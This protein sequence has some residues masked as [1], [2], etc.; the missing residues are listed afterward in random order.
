VKS[1]GFMF[2]GVFETRACSSSVNLGFLGYGDLVRQPQ[3][4]N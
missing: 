2:A 1:H 4:R 3:A